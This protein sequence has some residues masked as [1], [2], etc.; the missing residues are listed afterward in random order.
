MG[1]TGRERDS[2]LEEPEADVRTGCSRWP[3][4][5][6][7]VVLQASKELPTALRGGCAGSF[8]GPLIR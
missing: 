7:D 5:P 8:I 6:R 1:V 4:I 2:Q 3:Q